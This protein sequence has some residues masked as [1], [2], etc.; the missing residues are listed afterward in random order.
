MRAER[1]C[2]AALAR[3]ES[4]TAGRTAR[5]LQARV[6]HSMCEAVRAGKRRQSAAFRVGG[7]KAFARETGR[8]F[9]VFGD[10]G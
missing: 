1:N 6:H 3:A 8:L 4:V 10:D 7:D 5:V 9:T 2:S